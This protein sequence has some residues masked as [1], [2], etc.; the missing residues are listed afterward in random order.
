MIWYEANDT[1]RTPSLSRLSVSVKE[2]NSK[3]QP[4]SLR[5]EKYENSPFALVN[6][7]REVYPVCKHV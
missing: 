2:G 3:H 1:E 6:H 5:G 7:T 4:D